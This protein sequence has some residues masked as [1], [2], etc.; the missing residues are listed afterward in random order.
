MMSGEALAAQMEFA[1]NPE[2]RCPVVLLLDTS[3]SMHGALINELNNGVSAFRQGIASDGLASKRVEL[4]IVEFNSRVNVLQDFA[5][6]ETLEPPT[7]IAGGGTYMA[8]GINKALDMLE[9]R[10]KLYR[11][12]GIDFYR[13]WIFLIT[14]G[15]PGD[16]ASVWSEACE[17]VRSSEA[18]KKV[19]FFAVGV[20]SA[21]LKKLSELS[22]R[23][24]LKLKGQCFEELFEWLSASLSSVSQSNVGDDVPLSAVNGWAVV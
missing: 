22:T 21:N 13:P 8:S 9:T 12:S 4:A 15:A 10:K 19:A 6:V 5:T 17:R 18:R 24:P 1:D 23:M 2:P 14:D 16:P 20:E 3:S 7:L 11:A